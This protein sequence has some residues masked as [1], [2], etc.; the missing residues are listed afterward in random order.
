VLE[1]GRPVLFMGGFSGSDPVVNANSLAKLV[2]AG[3]L[4][5]I[6][7]GGFGG[8]GGR[9]G[10]SNVSSWIQSS[11]SVVSQYSQATGSGFRGGSTLYQCGA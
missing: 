8:F 7:Y 11:C 6:L 5:Y 4:R 1:T 9:G 10:G 2:A 3:E